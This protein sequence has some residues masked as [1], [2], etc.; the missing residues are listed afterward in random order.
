V[1]IAGNHATGNQLFGIFLRDAMKGTVVGNEVTGSCVGVIVIGNASGDLVIAGINVHENNAF[2]PPGGD[3]GDVPLSGIGI[4]LASA[5]RNVIT[6]NRITGHVPGGEVLFSGGVVIIDASDGVD[7]PSDNRIV[8]NTFDG[9]QVDVFSDGTGV[10]NIVAGNAYSVSVPDGLCAGQGRCAPG[11][12]TTF[13]LHRHPNV[14]TV[15]PRRC[16]ATRVRPVAASLGKGES[17]SDLGDTF[18]NDPP[19]HPSAPLLADDEA[20]L[21]ER[22]GVMAHRGL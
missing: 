22:L 15:P 6:G 11:W 16:S 5:D 8:G 3:E 19:P 13:P 12:P 2:C 1:L 17:V 10:R 4:A 7:V 20:G 14:P 18:R 21:G 9:N